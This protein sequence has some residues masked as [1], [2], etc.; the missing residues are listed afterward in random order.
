MFA[1]A[2]VLL[3]DD[4]PMY[5]A[6]LRALLER[7]PAILVEEASTT[8]EAE[9]IAQSHPIDI[10][11]ID[12]L[13]PESGGP[14]MVRRLKMLRPTCKI[15]A[16]SVLD[17]PLRVTEMLRAGAAGYAVKSQPISEIVNALQAVSGGLRYLAPHLS[18]ARI[19]ELLRD[20][21]SDPMQRLTIRERRVFDLLVQGN[22]NRKVASLLDIARSTVE[23][24][25]RQIMRKLEASSIVDLVHLALRQGAI[26][27][28]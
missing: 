4:H 8:A 25:R 17:E 27:M 13:V 21:E 23:T 5:R 9:A 19:D 3:V 2:R 7:Q 20:S 6:G 10:A 11:C 22:S 14:A 26:G 28:S 18:E 15:L 24:H 16:L 1:T 12:V